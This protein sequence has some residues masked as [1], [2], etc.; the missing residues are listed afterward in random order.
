MSWGFRRWTW[1][2]YLIICFFREFI[3]FSFSSKAGN[4][5]LLSSIFYLL[6]CVLGFG[7]WIFSPRAGL[8]SLQAPPPAVCAPWRC[9]DVTTSGAVRLLF[10]SCFLPLHKLLLC[11]GRRGPSHEVVCT[12]SMQASEDFCFVNRMSTARRSAS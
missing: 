1:L 8:P 4:A 11:P 2:L 3:F 9:R 7:L 12:V 10:V 6:F 5:E